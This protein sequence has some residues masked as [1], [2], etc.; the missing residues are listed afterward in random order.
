MELQPVILSGGSGTRLWPLSRE[1]YPKQ[2]LA[3]VGDETMLQA[4]AGRLAGFAGQLSV[5]S[6]PI[7][8]CNEEYRFV[9]AEQLRS[10]G[11][12]SS[13]IL[14]EPVVGRENLR[15]NVTADIDFA[16]IESTEEAFKPNQG[17]S[18]PATVRSQQTTEQSGSNPA[19]A[20]G[21]P[22]ATSNQPPLPAAAPVTGAAAPPT[23]TSAAAISIRENVIGA[24]YRPEA[25]D[26]NNDAV[27]YGATIGGPDAARFVMNP[28]TREIRFAA[29]PNFEAPADAGGNN[30]YDIS[31]TASDGTATTTQNV[32]VT[33]TNVANGFRVR[34]VTSGLS[35]PIYAAVSDRIAIRV[36]SHR[37]ID[38]AD[39][40]FADRDRCSRRESRWR[41]RPSRRRW[42]WWWW[43]R[44]GW[45]GWR[46]RWRWA[47]AS[48]TSTC[49]DR[50]RQSRQ[51][52]RANGLGHLQ[53]PHSP[54]AAKIIR[55]AA[56][57][58]PARVISFANE[59]GS[60]YR[61][62]MD[63]GSMTIGLDRLLK[64]RVGRVAD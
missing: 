17:A 13:N 58:R 53:T 6:A 64:G 44:S 34:R 31:F 9:T 39:Y 18:A 63:T 25:T 12:P 51:Q 21:V 27:T 57:E 50:Q 54:P 37:T 19:Q 30:V 40:I 61:E 24:I 8:V 56:A 59:N 14:L 43:W 42:W 1:Q 20:A 5:A 26:A 55:P 35:Q 3:L 36:S 10:N 62:K 22:G 15:A 23:F 47:G 4:T 41:G 33:V 52:G 7:V 48:S 45:R 32:A 29:A 11:R 28:V 38:R 60:Q 49:Y 2:L 46:W 16:Q